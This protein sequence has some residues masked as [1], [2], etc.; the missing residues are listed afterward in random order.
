[1]NGTSALQNSNRKAASQL[2]V[3]GC[4]GLLAMNQLLILRANKLLVSA[5]LCCE[6]AGAPTLQMDL[7][8]KDQ[9]QKGPAGARHVFHVPGGLACTC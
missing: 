1:M 8:Q 6:D 9:R 3:S 7:T 2:E 4:P 5:Q